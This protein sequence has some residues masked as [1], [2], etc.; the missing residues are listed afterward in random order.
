[1]LRAP[2]GDSALQKRALRVRDNEVRGKLHLTDVSF[3]DDDEL[4]E[5]IRAVVKA[6]GRHI[7]AESPLCDAR[8][9]DG[10]RL[11][12]VLPPVSKPLVITIRKQQLR[13]F[14]GL[15]DLVV[16]GTNSAAGAVTALDLARR[17]GTVVLLGISGAGK[18]AVDPDTISL[19][20]L[21][22][23][24]VFA[25]SRAAW[26]WLVSLYGAGLFAPDVLITHRYGLGE[27]PKAFEVLG[28]RGANAVKVIVSPN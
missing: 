14:L 19:G 11:N 28:D 12:A 25:A 13:R 20:H 24:G 3:R 4:L 17:A 5:I 21:R 2:H 10:S 23:Q 16:E 9:P 7:D 6:A 22:V 8:L 26:Q 27:A 1:M 15:P 18:P